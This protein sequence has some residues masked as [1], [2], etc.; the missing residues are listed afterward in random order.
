MKTTWTPEKV[1]SLR[2]QHKLSK[3]ALGE[4]VGVST[5]FIYYLEKGVRNPSKTLCLLL[6]RIE[7]E[8]EE[9]DKEKGR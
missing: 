4:L 6:D 8:L 7:K 9:N 5:N 2:D 3:R 1:R